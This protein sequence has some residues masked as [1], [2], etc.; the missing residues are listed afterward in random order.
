MIEDDARDALRAA[1]Q[2]FIELTRILDE[3]IA[4][5]RAVRD[6]ELL[7]RLARAKSAADQGETL[8]AKI[9]AIIANDAGQHCD[10]LG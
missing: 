5:A 10:T 9:D 6:D 7:E 8:I 1:S 2:H 4:E 3:A